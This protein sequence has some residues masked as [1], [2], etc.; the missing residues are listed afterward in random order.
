MFTATGHVLVG[1]QSRAGTQSWC[2]AQLGSEVG[3]RKER[4]VAC[5]CCRGAR[6]GTLQ[7]QILHSEPESVL[8]QRPILPL[9]WRTM[10]VCLVGDEPRLAPDMVFTAPVA[11]Q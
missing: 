9:A 4:D 5:R 6:G 7:P 1:G 8:P 11:S 2:R 10:A 3:G